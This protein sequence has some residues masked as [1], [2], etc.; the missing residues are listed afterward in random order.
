[1]ARG[2][3]NSRSGRGARGAGPEAHARLALGVLTAFVLIVAGLDSAARNSPTDPRP[4]RQTGNPSQCEKWGCGERGA[5]VEGIVRAVSP[6]FGQRLEAPRPIDCT[7][8]C[9]SRPDAWSWAA[10]RL[11]AEVNAVIRHF[12][13]CV[14]RQSN[15]RVSDR[16]LILTCPA[17]GPP[18]TA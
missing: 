12:G 1:M 5:R 18:A 2:A 10:I 7:S 3:E 8:S 15:G 14:L 17:Q 13:T 6:T 11:H 4:A 9:R 16:P